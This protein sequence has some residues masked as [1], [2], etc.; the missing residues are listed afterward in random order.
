MANELTLA[1]QREL[2]ALLKD[3]QDIRQDIENSRQKELE[4]FEGIIDEQDKKNLLAKDMVATLEKQIEKLEGLTDK[5]KEFLNLNEE[6]LAE[7]IRK[8]KELLAVEQKLVEEGKQRRQQLEK[9]GQAADFLL[10]RT[11]GITEETK[12]YGEALKTPGKFLGDM[13][14]LLAKNLTLTNLA[15][16]AAA[17][18]AESFARASDYMKE[19]FGV[20]GQ[21]FQQ[22]KQFYEESRMIARE[23]GVLGER[24][25]QSF[26]ENMT[27]IAGRTIMTRQEA[28]LAMRDMRQSSALF[29]QSIAEDQAAM[30]ELSDTMRRTQS[31]G[32]S[33]F[34][35]MMETL[36]FT[37]GK[38]RTE[39]LQ[40]TAN[41]GLMADKLN[42]DV[43]K[44]IGD[45]SSQANN[46]VKFLIIKY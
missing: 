13:G 34:V 15:G 12:K 18:M 37:M 16:S 6:A 43:N 27:A 5:Q 11:F 28:M 10:Q 1:Q 22:A 39:A 38:S 46:L 41:F 3:E 35:G 29:R 4:A 17:K 44:A 20:F 21:P 33:E 19:S 36:T 32:G 7:E 31:V 8:K 9:S 42:L 30:I 45:F 26:Q 2:N 25:L 24:E 40:T 14:K 23:V